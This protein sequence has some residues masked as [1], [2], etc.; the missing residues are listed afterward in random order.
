MK[1]EDHLDAL[2]S[3]AKSSPVPPPS[4]GLISRVLAD[5]ASAVPVAAPAPAA[6]KPGLLSRLLSPIGGLG[7]A[8]ALGA[9]AAFGVVIGAGYTETLLATPGLETVL[10]AF[11]DSADATSPFE[12][13]TLLMSES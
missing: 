11:S 10:S 8:F 7:G 4:Q 12:T 1:S 2:L 13:L 9:C 5:A 6:Q 3:E